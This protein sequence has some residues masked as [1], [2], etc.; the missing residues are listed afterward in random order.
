MQIEPHCSFS[1]SF[2]D[3]P[4]RYHILKLKPHKPIHARTPKKK[5]K[6]TTQKKNRSLLRKPS[7]VMG[8]EGNLVAHT[9][10]LPLLPCLWV[11]RQESLASVGGRHTE[12]VAAFGCV[13]VYVSGM[14]I[15]W[16]ANMSF[17]CVYAYQ[18]RFCSILFGAADS[19]RHLVALSVR[20]M[21][22]RKPTHNGHIYI[23]IGPK[24]HAP[25]PHYF[26]SYKSTKKKTP[27][28]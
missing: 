18:Q 11:A 7:S 10:H 27:K 4:I 28:K 21:T 25:A 24:I 3:R 12:V 19:N 14:H 6:N 1:F 13:H 26:L 17:V 8:F 2:A 15:V 16:D 9:L 22:H 5:T 20:F 23:A